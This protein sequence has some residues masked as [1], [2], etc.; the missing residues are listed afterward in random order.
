MLVDI[1][2]MLSISSRLAFNISLYLKACFKYSFAFVCFKFNTNIP[3][4]IQIYT[5]IVYCHYTIYSAVNQHHINI[6]LRN[7]KV[8][9]CIEEQLQ[10]VNYPSQIVMGRVIISLSTKQLLRNLLLLYLPAQCQSGML[11]LH[12]RA[13][14]SFLIRNINV[15]HPNYSQFSV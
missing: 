8:K 9:R 3:L 10:K 13:V 14:Q 1:E 4:F 15:I 6:L 7:V 2:R 11:L 5:N 12:N